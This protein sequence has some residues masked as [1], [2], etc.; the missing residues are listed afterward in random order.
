MNARFTALV[1]S[2]LTAVTSLTLV[3]CTTTTNTVV[4]KPNEDGGE[5]EDG[6]VPE[7][8]GEAPSN[9]P[10]FEPATTVATVKAADVT[11][12]SGIATSKKNPGVFWLHNDS[13]D[14]ARA[15]AI[16]SDGELKATLSFDT[17]K[18]NDIEDIAIE[19]DGATSWLY[20]ADMGDNAEARASITIHRVEE[21]K[22][23]SGAAQVLTATSEKMTVVYPDGPHNAESLLFDPIDKQLVIFTKVVG[24]PAAFHKIGK[25]AAGTKVTTEKIGEFTFTLATGGEISRDGK[26]IAVRSL[27][28]TGYLWTRAD[29]ESLEAAIAKKPCSIPIPD[30]GQGEALDFLPDGSGYVTVTEG[31]SPP[32]KLTS[33]K[34]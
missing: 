3:R 9:C 15:F 2:G 12:T 26:Y 29:G 33:F 6:A 14:T 5:E 10:S 25:F 11:E 8:D 17:A 34:K 20:F 19:D 21:P 28:K 16:G 27:A 30:V 7:E 18:P 13:G 22:L 4:V 24:K 32:I 1:L 31:S 23:G